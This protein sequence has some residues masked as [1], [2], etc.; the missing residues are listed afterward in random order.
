MSTEYFIHTKPSCLAAGN[1]K[2]K[3]DLKVQHAPRP[4]DI[5]RTPL[6]L[7]CG[8]VKSV[9]LGVSVKATWSSNIKSSCKKKNSG[10]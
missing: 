6:T 1:Q 9:S 4:T 3:A 8:S 5:K 10:R 7:L 2:E